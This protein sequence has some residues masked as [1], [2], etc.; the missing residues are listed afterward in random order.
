MEHGLDRNPRRSERNHSL[1]V[2]MHNALHGREAG[3]NLAMY[4]SFAVPSRLV[5]MH[6]L[7]AVGEVFDEVVPGRY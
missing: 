2:R 4:E 1:R 5:V 6:R 7:R 3:V